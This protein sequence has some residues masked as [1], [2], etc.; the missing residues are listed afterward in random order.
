[1]SARYPKHARL[2]TS[3]EFA[4]VRRKGRRL[5]GSTLIIDIK[6]TKKS[7]SRLG[8]SVS[9]RYGKAVKRNR[10]KRQIREL[11][12]RHSAQFAE[13]LDVHVSPQFKHAPYTYPSLTQEFIKLLN[14]S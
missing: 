6:P 14:I 3:K 9:R 10:F 11:F 8:L 1:M 5:W 2:L 12:R 13:P 7:T 4:F